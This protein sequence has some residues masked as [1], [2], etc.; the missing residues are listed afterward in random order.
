MMQLLLKIVAVVIAL[1]A[2]FAIGS[3]Q[4]S[5]GNP[6]V[7]GDAAAQRVLSG[8][9]VGFRL[10]GERNGK[11]QGK[12]VVRVD[13]KWVEVEFATGMRLLTK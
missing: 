8:A 10:E 11:P 3:A 9:D 7:Q 6:P 2:T 5:R 1:A 4:G 13:G 12:L